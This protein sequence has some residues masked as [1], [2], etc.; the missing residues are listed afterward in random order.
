Q[1]FP[2]SEV[3]ALANEC[4]SILELDRHNF[5]LSPWYQHR[6]REKITILQQ[7]SAYLQLTESPR[8]QKLIEEIFC[9]SPQILKRKLV[10]VKL[11]NSPM[12][13][14]AHYDYNYVRRSSATVYTAWLPIDDIPANAGGITYLANSQLITQDWEQQIRRQ[15]LHLPMEAQQTPFQKVFDRHGWI[16]KDLLSLAKRYNSRWLIGDFT[17][18]DVLFH[19]PCLIHAAFMNSHSHRQV[20]LST[21]IRFQ[22]QTSIP[23]RHWQQFWQPFDELNLI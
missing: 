21:D 13:T 18:G 17:A 1:L 22:S 8:L 15:T 3:L 20:C 14:G 6:I 7:S 11:P 10:R 23:D 12:N 9:F 5:T 2:R 19:H 4:H 16:N